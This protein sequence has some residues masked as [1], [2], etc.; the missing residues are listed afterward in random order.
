MS[1]DKD[2]IIDTSSKRSPVTGHKVYPEEELNKRQP[3][4]EDQWEKETRIEVE[5]KTLHIIDKYF[6]EKIVYELNLDPYTWPGNKILRGAK[7][8]FEK[9]LSKIR[10][11]DRERAKERGKPLLRKTEN[12]SKEH[13]RKRKEQ[14]IRAIEKA[15]E[16]LNEEARRFGQNMDNDPFAFEYYLTPPR[17]KKTREDM[18]LGVVAEFRDED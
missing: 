13:A 17:R 8:G 9:S 6:R 7:K 12:E 2:I 1:E 18:I 11:M 14:R 10:I 4:W 16:D 3:E 5:G 15:I